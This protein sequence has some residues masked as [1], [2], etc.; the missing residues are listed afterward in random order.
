MGDLAPAISSPSSA[1]GYFMSLR[2]DFL[3]E[4]SPIDLPSPLSRVFWLRQAPE[5]RTL[6]S[7]ANPG[8]ACASK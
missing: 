8:P 5:R 6:R 7:M 1:H 3:L 4:H 2:L